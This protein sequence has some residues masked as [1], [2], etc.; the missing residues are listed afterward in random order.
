[1]GSGIEQLLQEGIISEV[2]GR[3]QSGKEAE[4][5]VVRYGDQV[6]AAKVYK[7]HAQ[8]SF[9]NN[10]SYKEGRAVRNTR[11][12]RAMNR[13]SRFGK[14]AAEEAWKSAEADALYKL[15][16]ADVRVPTPVLFF[17]GVLLMEL[18]LD[19][20][21]NTARRLI[22]TAL[23]AEQA[24]LAYHDMLRQLV[25]MLACDLIHGDLSPYNVLWG[26]GGVTIIDF[27]QIVSASH[28]SSSERFFMRDAENILGHFAAID[29][30]LQARRS[31]PAE[32]WQAYRRRELSPDFLP[33]GRARLPPPQRPL[34]IQASRPQQ[35]QGGYGAPRPQQGQQGQGYGAARP[36][37]G[38]Q[39][40]GYGG[41]RPQQGQQGQGYGA[42]RPQQSNGQ[43]YGPP[44]PPQGGG[45][46]QRGGQGQQGPRPQQGR[47]Q[48]FGAPRQQGQGNGGP[49]SPQG[50]Q[51]QQGPGHGAPRQQ[52]PGPR[53][54]G[55]DPRSQ[56]TAE[57]QHAPRGQQAPR[58]PSSPQQGRNQQSPRQPAF[59]GERRVKA[60]P[61]VIVR[62]R[63]AAPS[64][65]RPSEAGT[66]PTEARKPSPKGD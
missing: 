39:G 20:D 43:G 27:P 45:A 49:R 10:S 1:M 50:Q 25:R 29:P 14:D 66:S 26:V 36:Q 7:D 65:A 52:G 62:P 53:H 30:R 2:V 12:Q 22:D 58:G 57:Q 63:S 17:E 4:V 33:S 37:Q 41:P 35:A 11:D 32:I 13:G 23:T 21:G 28:N 6:V 16:A 9:K 24:N 3:L 42:S 60:M 61:E 19:A 48:A 47:G 5:F 8:R 40:Q 38:Q 54:G 64:P 15:H 51:R 56:R 18:V 59:G 55:Q 46:P 34:P 44:R 31:D